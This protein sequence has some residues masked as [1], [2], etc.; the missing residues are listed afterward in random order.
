MIYGRGYHFGLLNLILLRSILADTLVMKHSEDVESFEN[1]FWNFLM[2]V[3]PLR[4]TPAWHPYKLRN[5]IDKI[6]GRDIYVNYLV[7]KD[8]KFTNTRN[9]TVEH[10]KVIQ[11][12]NVTDQYSPSLK[13]LFGELQLFATKNDK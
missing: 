10:L 9:V 7:K 4:W 1:N 12:W 11:D 3:S 5:D 6:R 13:I 2:R 8:K